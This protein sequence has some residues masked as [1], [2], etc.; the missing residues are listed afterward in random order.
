MAFS[1]GRDEVGDSNTGRRTVGTPLHNDICLHNNR[2]HRRRNRRLRDQRRAQAHLRRS[3][4]SQFVELLDVVGNYTLVESTNTLP[5]VRHESVLSA[6]S[7]RANRFRGSTI[8]SRG[9][10]QQQLY[11]NRIDD[12][13]TVQI[14]EPSVSAADTMQEEHERLRSQVLEELEMRG[15]SDEVL[16]VH[17]VAPGSKEDGVTRL[18]Y[19]NANGI[20]CRQLDGRKVMKARALHNRL[21]ADIVAYS[22][23]QLNYR[24]PGNRTG[25]NQLFRGGE[26]DI[27]SIVAHNVHENVNRVQEGGTAMMV[28]GPMIQHRCPEGTQKDETG[29]GRWVVTTLTGH[30]GF[31]TR[32]IC[33]YNPCGNSNLESGTVYAQHRRYFM[34]RGCLTCP[35]V[36]FRQD[37]QA[38]LQRW[39]DQGDRL[40]VCLDANEHIY[41]K[42]I[43]K[44]LMDPNSLA[45]R[46]VVGTFTGKKIGPTFFRG[47]KPI[48]GVWATSEVNITAAC[49][50]PAGFGIGDHRLFVVD[51]LTSSLV[52]ANPVKILRP[53]ARRLNTKLPG[54]VARYNDKLEDLVL[55]HRII[56]RMGEAHENSGTDAEAKMKMDV[57]DNEFKEY[58]KSAEK[59][60]RTI[61]S[62]TIP[63]SP[64]S[65][66]W[67]RRCRVYTT[68]LAMSTGRR[69]NRGNLIR[70]AR[71]AGI[72][73]PFDL[74]ELEIRGRLRTCKEH[75]EYYR[76][77]GLPYRRRHLLRRA[78]VARK[79]GNEDGA[80]EILAMIARERQRD[81]WRSMKAGMQSQ[82]GRSV[83]AV[84]VEQDNGEVVEYTNQSDIEEAIWTNIHRRR[85]FWLKK[86]LSAKAAC[87]ATSVTQQI[88]LLQ[89]QSSMALT[90]ET[91]I[92]IQLR[93]KCLT[94]VLGSGK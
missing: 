85:F 64:E 9:T 14:D 73:T 81:F 41:K 7:T 87:V 12:T 76:D 36:K 72:L 48:D 33:G 39:R 38:A 77:H 6:L 56:E 44:M 75:C 74:T 15:V 11:R 42:S 51:I 30:Q 84:Q 89:G 47:S 5:R 10:E 31:T 34:N 79:E 62:G 52:G 65:E 50:M 60:C 86:H 24:H 20:D 82:S 26:T 8:H 93:R 4:D 59:S 69:V 49:V 22:E 58:K 32:I 17:G 23:H 37:L 28:F 78:E 45:M 61:K 71:R 18:I 88:L 2:R 92:L 53:C 91:T 68:L 43:G 29:L 55:E 46:E 1:G 90:L 16:R 27:R 19:E 13:G 21:E 80:K 70:S 40:I 25:F 66:I 67:I 94:L 35:R 54:V 83:Q 63:F 57:V 3:D